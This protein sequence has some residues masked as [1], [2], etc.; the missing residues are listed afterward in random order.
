MVIYDALYSDLSVK[1][2]KD[3]KELKQMLVDVKFK[4]KLA[5]P[6]TIEYLKNEGITIEE[7]QIKKKKQEETYNN[8]YDYY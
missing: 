1:K 3:E 8:N 7:K 4:G 5:S 2:I 6:S